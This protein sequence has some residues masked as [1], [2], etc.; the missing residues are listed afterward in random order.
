MFHN[1]SPLNYCLFCKYYNKKNNTNQYY[2]SFLVGEVDTAEVFR[3]AENL[4]RARRRTAAAPELYGVI[5]YKIGPTILA[6]NK[7]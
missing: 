3:F 1:A 6:I 4:G 5:G 7:V 2:I